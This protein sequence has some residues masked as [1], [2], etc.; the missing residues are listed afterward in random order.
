MS[1][2]RF[3]PAIMKLERPGPRRQ[4]EFLAAVRR[5]R[6]LHA[7]YVE[8]PSTPGEY[9]HYLRRQRRSAQVSFFVIDGDSDRL[10]GV[11]NVND[12]VG[13]SRRTASLGYYAFVPFAGRGLMR[14][15]LGIVVGYC[16]AKLKLHR[17]EASIQPGNRRSL[18]LVAGLG[19]TLE[20]TSRRCLK[21]R[22]RWRD[23]QRWALLADDWRRVGPAQRR[24]ARRC[25]QV[26]VSSTAS[27]PR[28]SISSAAAALRKPPVNAASNSGSARGPTSSSEGT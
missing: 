17:L 8:P 4:E 26:Q 23:H 27:R 13:D 15:A 11:V 14:E 2:R 21:I 3:D 9:A 18:A 5:S 10:A 24:T 20:G 6:A 7:A 28:A 12:I 22:G 19:F 25:R 1:A 16:F